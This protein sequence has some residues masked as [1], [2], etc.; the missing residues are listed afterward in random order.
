MRKIVGMS[1]NIK[2]EWLNEVANL[3]LVYDNEAEIKEKLNEYLALYIASPTNL[4]KTREIL[5]NIW[6]KVPEEYKYIRDLALKVFNS[7]KASNKLVA[8]WCMMVL[9]YPVF[10]DTCS[11]IG[12]MQDKQYDITTN[13]IKGKVYSIWGERT[14]LLHSLDKII[15]T[16]KDLQVI[17]CIKVGKFEVNNTLVSSKDAVVLIVATILEIKDK[18]YCS[19]ADLNGAAE[20]FPFDYIIDLEYLQESGVFD[21]DKFGGEISISKISEF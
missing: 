1:R 16:L 18:L 7:N 13:Q 12:K 14:T 21:F 5:L 2:L 17:N 11:V 4:R 19:V 6:I 10:A 15:S 8:H 3:L 9:I 20:F